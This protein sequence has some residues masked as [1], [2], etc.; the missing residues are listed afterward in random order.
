MG[1]SYQKETRTHGAFSSATASAFISVEKNIITEARIAI[2][3]VLPF[4][5]RLSDTE[6]LLTG[7]KPNYLL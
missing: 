5:I 6:T 2:G 1:F 3:S 7:K 4:P